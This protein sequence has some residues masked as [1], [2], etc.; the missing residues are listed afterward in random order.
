[1]YLRADKEELIENNRQFSI[2]NYGS[3]KN[4]YIKMAILQKQL[5]FDNSLLEMKPTACYFTDLQLCYSRQLSNAGSAVEEL[6]GQ[7]SAAMK[8][9]ELG[10]ETSLQR[11]CA[12]TSHLLSLIRLKRKG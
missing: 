8:L 11:M 9:L 5:V 2:A 3:R 10:K 1:M 6:V 4:Y 7:N 12:E